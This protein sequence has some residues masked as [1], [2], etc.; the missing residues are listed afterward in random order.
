MG[1]LHVPQ[2]LCPTRRRMYD[3]TYGV[4]RGG[5]AA[6]Q[7]ITMPMLRSSMWWHVVVVI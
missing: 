5:Y 2:L 4:R 7:T 6:A 3:I 1:T